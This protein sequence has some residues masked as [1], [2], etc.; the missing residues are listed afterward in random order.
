[1]GTEIPGS[2]GGVGGVG[3]GVVGGQGVCEGGM[4]GGGAV[5]LPLHCHHQSYFC[6]MKGSNEGTLMCYYEG[7]SHNTVST[8]HNLKQKREKK[9]RKEKKKKKKR[10]KRKDSIEPI[11]SAHQ[12]NA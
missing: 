3:V 7:Q 1:M 5:C 11:S 12:P 8:N 2:G 10:E 4:G 9:K 6:K